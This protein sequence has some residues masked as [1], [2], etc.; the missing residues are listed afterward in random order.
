M[1]LFAFIRLF[2]GKLSR[3][4]HSVDLH[5]KNAAEALKTTPNIDALKMF[6]GKEVSC[7][8]HSVDVRFMDGHPPG[9]MRKKQK[10]K[11]NTLKGYFA[12]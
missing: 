2:G 6:G 12:L 3:Q 11:A 1:E 10:I 7:M 5:S 9:A 4:L 8:L